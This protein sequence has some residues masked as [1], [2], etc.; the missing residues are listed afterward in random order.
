MIIAIAGATGSL[1]QFI[2]AACL[3]TPFRGSFREV[4]ILT[5]DPSSNKAKELEKAGAVVKKTDF[6]QTLKE[7][8]KDVSIFIDV[9]GS[10]GDSHKNKDLLLDA[11]LASDSV[12]YYIP[13]EFGVDTRLVGD[14]LHPEWGLKLQREKKARE[15]GKF[16]VISIFTGLFMEGSFGPW[17]GFDVQNQVFTAIGNAD[18]PFSVTSQVDIGLAVASI[19]SLIAKGVGNEIPDHVNISGSSQTINQAAEIFNK[20]STSSEK[21]KEANNENPNIVKKIV[22]EILPHH[23]HQAIKVEIIPIESFKKDTLAKPFDQNFLD[24]LRISISEG[25]IDYGKDNSNKLVNPN[26]MWKFTSLEEY[27]KSVNGRPWCS[28]TP[29]DSRNPIERVNAKIGLPK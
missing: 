16:K 8:L 2:T 12:K 9:L 3:N 28:D 25:K 13:S 18:I 19:C 4:R 11:V 20:Y 7:D 1:G 6:N 24:F 29:Q 15:L 27:A 10:N 26:S 17:L 5:R 21:N 22:N 23:H 14:Y